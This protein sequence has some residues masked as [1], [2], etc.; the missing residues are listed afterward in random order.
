MRDWPM[1][2]GVAV[3]MLAGYIGASWSLRDPDNIGSIRRAWRRSVDRLQ[4]GGRAFSRLTRGQRVGVL[5]L[6]VFSLFI[7]L[8]AVFALAKAANTEQGVIVGFLALGVIAV[9]GSVLGVSSLMARFRSS[10]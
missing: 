5:W 6:A 10:A 2:M 8:R 7:L 9:A 3:L 4:R 1:V